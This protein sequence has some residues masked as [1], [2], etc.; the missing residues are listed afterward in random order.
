MKELFD[1][2][3]DGLIIVAVG[4]ALSLVIAYPLMLLWNGLIPAI[5][6]LKT[7]TFWEAFGL[8]ILSGVLF[9]NPSLDKGKSE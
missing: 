7:I 5:F 4:L 9:R 1:S 6:G 8:Y 3:F 2:G